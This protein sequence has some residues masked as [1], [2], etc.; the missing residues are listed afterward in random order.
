MSIVCPKCGQGY[1]VDQSIIGQQV[2]CES[3]GLN[4]IA[5]SQKLQ[6]RR[7]QPEKLSFKSIRV[8]GISFGIT[9]LEPF[10]S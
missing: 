7:E 2:E 8:V 5:K 9:F 3:C 4:F 10:Y 6:A 1:D